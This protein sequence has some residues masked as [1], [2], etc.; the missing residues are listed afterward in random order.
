MLPWP[1]N[2]ASGMQ[3]RAKLSLYAGA[4]AAHLEHQQRNALAA[5]A[6]NKAA[7]RSILR[8]CS[9]DYRTA[10]NGEGG[11]ATTAGS[12][13]CSSSS[14]LGSNHQAIRDLHQEPI[15][16]LAVKAS[17]EANA[18]RHEACGGADLAVEGS[19]QQRLLR[20]KRASTEQQGQQRQLQGAPNSLMGQNQ[21]Q[22]PLQRLQRQK[23]HTHPGLLEGYPA[24]QCPGGRRLK[25]MYCRSIQKSNSK[26]SANCSTG[27]CRS[28]NTKASM[29]G[30]G[31][32]SRCW[33]LPM[34]QPEGGNATATTTA[35]MTAVTEAATQ[36]RAASAANPTA[37]YVA[38]QSALGRMC[39][40][41]AKERC[42]NHEG[43][44][45]SCRA[46]GC[47]ADASVLAAS[48]SAGRTYNTCYDSTTY[49][50]S[51]SSSSS[52]VVGFI[53]NRGLSKPSN[54]TGRGEACARVKAPK[55]SLQQQQH[56][57]QQPSGHPK[58]R[59]S[60]CA[61][62]G[63]IGSN[64][65]GKGG[66]W[67]ANQLRN[68]FSGSSCC[69]NR[70]LVEEQIKSCKNSSSRRLMPVTGVIS[71]TN[72]RH[73][74]SILLR[75]HN[76]R[77]VSKK[78][79]DV[80]KALGK[81]LQALVIAAA[82]VAVGPVSPSNSTVALPLG[83][84]PLGAV[85]SRSFL[86]V[87]TPLPPIFAFCFLP[88]LGRCLLMSP[89]GAPHTFPAPAV[90]QIDS[91]VWEIGPTLRSS[92]SQNS[93]SVMAGT[94]EFLN[95]GPTSGAPQSVVPVN[96]ALQEGPPS[97][98]SRRDEFY[99]TDRLPHAMVLDAL[100]YVDPLPAE[101]QQQVQQ[102]L[103]Q[104]MAAIAREAGGPDSLPDYLSDLPIPKTPVLDD[105]ETMLGKEIA[106]KAKG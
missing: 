16:A 90:Q 26:G 40:F 54:Q 1:C 76:G 81:L 88:P 85:D 6:A 93:S 52:S 10:A 22:V 73:I 41:P 68:C 48:A 77:N 37:A 70:A 5:A 51:S 35:S 61:W 7:G 25:V 27:K 20:T 24:F 74:N 86:F 2:A 59:L 98:D 65:S 75:P 57:Q 56:R 60:A 80:G 69:C 31:R 47:L 42:N 33:L 106:R 43:A 53:A 11:T 104:E 58:V 102:L 15:S 87:A 92:S 95:G 72:M 67:R 96:G 89:G 79:G 49:H 101:Q 62:I 99:L 66:P 71:S 46:P 36:Q 28:S 100:P 18:A 50:S 44:Y 105:A 13:T 97:P 82:R 12:I 55:T 63:R 94:G 78:Q 91:F 4:L 17:T 3:L 39:I 64:S 9:K 103:Q 19:K 83:L 38:H 14:G 34:L 45:N 29:I 21:Q 32:T 84:M 8:G 30:I 23:E